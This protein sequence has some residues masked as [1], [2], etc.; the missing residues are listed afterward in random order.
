MPTF[1][2]VFSTIKEKNEKEQNFRN[3][4]TIE[5]EST[6]S[7]SNMTLQ[8][9]AKACPK[10]PDSF[11]DPG[12]QELDGQVL[13]PGAIKQALHLPTLFETPPPPPVPHG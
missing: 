3:V 6:P 8:E 11:Q 1:V 13:P 10:P 5:A 7:H 9:G 4:G 2:T 12:S